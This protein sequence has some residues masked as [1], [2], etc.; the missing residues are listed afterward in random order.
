MA[1]VDGDALRRAEAYMAMV[2]IALAWVTLAF[3]VHTD[4]DTRTHAHAHTRTRTRARAA[5]ATAAVFPRCSLLRFF[6]LLSSSSLR[7]LCLSPD[8]HLSPP[9]SDAGDIVN[10]PSIIAE[11]KKYSRTF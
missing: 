8:W 7:L 9:K 6:F 11:I 1:R 3:R 2:S 10:I 4:M 5:A